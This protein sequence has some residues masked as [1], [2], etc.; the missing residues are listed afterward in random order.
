MQGAL[1]S[2]TAT[3]CL[4]LVNQR[5]AYLDAAAER[6]ER[7]EAFEREVRDGVPPL[8]LV[9]RHQGLHALF[10]HDALEV[11]GWYQHLRRSG[12]GPFRHLI[13]ES[14]ISTPFTDEPSAVH[15]ILRNRDGWEATGDDP[16]LVYSLSEPRFLAAI[17]ISV[18]YGQRTDRPAVFQVFWKSPGTDFSEDRSFTTKL[19]EATEPTTITV[20]IYDTIDGFRIDPSDKPGIIRLLE[21]TLVVPGKP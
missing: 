4:I 18:A 20:P 17:R 3:T 9:Q 16:S 13:V 21:I 19:I 8:V 11:A 12:V 6:L 1:L 10:G 2:A 15:Q 5:N 14:H 7:A